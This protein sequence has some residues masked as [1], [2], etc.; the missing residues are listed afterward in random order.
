MLTI[1]LSLYLISNFFFHKRNNT[2]RGIHKFLLLL[3]AFI[4]TY[5]LMDVFDLFAYMRSL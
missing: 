4:L 2:L 3:G 5:K 1:F